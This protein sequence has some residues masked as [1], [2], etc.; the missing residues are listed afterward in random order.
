M[1]A[2]RP[3]FIQK[4]RRAAGA[5]L[6]MTETRHISH[7]AQQNERLRVFAGVLQTSV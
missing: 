1:T 6:A 4:A 7:I 5:E 2:E 3:A